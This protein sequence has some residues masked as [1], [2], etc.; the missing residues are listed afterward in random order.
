[1][2]T[3]SKC[4]IEKDLSEFYLSKRDG[5]QP[6]C[7]SCTKSLTKRWK[8]ANPD[9]VKE[10][11]KKWDK[12]NAGKR[13]KTTKIWEANNPD[14]VRDK[15]LRNDYGITLE[16]YSQMLID[17]D[18]TCKICN[19]PESSIDPRTS[20]IKNLAVDHC[21]KSGKIRGLLCSY[22]NRGIGYLKEDI[23][24]LQ[25]AIKYLSDEQ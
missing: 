5:I 12:L 24:T 1:M 22:C 11:S 19:K 8:D 18:Y 16:Q 25:N 15:A 7:K 3:C 4:K 10:L 2:K 13:A 21:H 20:R 17:Q 14:K 23:S 9:K 6:A